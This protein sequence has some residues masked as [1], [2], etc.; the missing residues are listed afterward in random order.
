MDPTLAEM[1]SSRLPPASLP[2]P[3]SPNIADMLPSHHDASSESPDSGSTA[4][5]FSPIPFNLT[6]SQKPPPPPEF[7]D[8]SNPLIIHDDG[9]Q[10]KHPYLAPSEAPLP[11]L[12]GVLLVL[13]T[14]CVIGDS[15][16]THR[17]RV[18]GTTNLNASLYTLDGL[19]SPI[20]MIDNVGSTNELWLVWGHGEPPA[21]A[22]STRFTLCDHWTP[23]SVREA[24]NSSDSPPQTPPNT[25][26]D[27]LTHL[28]SWKQPEYQHHAIL[29]RLQVGAVVAFS[30]SAATFF[31][32]CGLVNRQDTDI[33][34]TNETCEGI[35]NLK[36]EGS[37]VGVSVKKLAGTPHAT[38]SLVPVVADFTR[39]LT[40]VS[41]RGRSVEIEG[42]L[43]APE[44]GEQSGAKHELEHQLTSTGADLEVYL[45]PWL[46]TV[47]LAGC[48]LYLS[49]FWIVNSVCT[50][51]AAH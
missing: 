14:A 24:H 29:E 41:P 43:G 51:A 18:G 8:D 32:Q 39:N 22:D 11:L 21:A 4:Q 47:L 20:M 5:D 7:T 10:S 12:V 3:I 28:D 17:L 2:D 33:M 40:V 38:D 13:A 30:H 44:L 46:E 34:I 50:S 15:F 27:P 42:A 45:L 1:I 16:L 48:S 31:P 49:V 26:L 6:P 35:K 37:S 25:P 36:L 23:S 19:S 9:Q